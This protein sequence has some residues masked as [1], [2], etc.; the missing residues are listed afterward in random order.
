M[1]P[2]GT[3]QS[4]N[5]KWTQ[6][7]LASLGLKLAALQYKLPFDDQSAD[8]VERLFHDLMKSVDTNKKLMIE[9][10]SLKEKN[11]QMEATL[12]NLLVQRESKTSGS[13]ANGDNTGQLE[14]RV[15]RLNR[16]VE[17]L[18]FISSKL[19]GVETAESWGGASLN[20]LNL[21]M[22]YEKAL[23]EGASDKKDSIDKKSADN[24]PAFIKEFHSVW[25]AQEERDEFAMKLREKEAEISNLL[26]MPPGD[27]N[28]VK[29][30]NDHRERLFR[31]SVEADLK[32]LARVEQ[33]RDIVTRKLEGGELK[34]A[35]SILGEVSR[36]QEKVKELETL[37]QEQ[38][39]MILRLEKKLAS[40]LKKERRMSEM[41]G[42]AETT[43]S[44]RG[45]QNRML[46][47]EALEIAKDAWRTERQ[48]LEA[49]RDQLEQELISTRKELKDTREELEAVIRRST[50]IAGDFDRAKDELAFSKNRIAFF[51]KAEIE[52]Q[53]TQSTLDKQLREQDKLLMELKN[54][55]QSKSRALDEMTNRFNDAGRTIVAQDAEMENLQREMRQLM[56]SLN[57]AQDNL[58]NANG[59]MKR[60][61][62]EL[63]NTLERA[64]AY[65]DRFISQERQK[66]ALMMEIQK[67]KEI[68]RA[69]ETSQE[70]IREMSNAYK[71]LS[72]RSR[73]LEQQLMKLSSER[74][75]YKQALL[76]AREQWKFSREEFASLQSRYRTLLNEYES[77]VVEKE[78]IIN[79]PF[80]SMPPSL[81]SGTRQDAEDELH[82]LREYVETLQKELS[83]FRK[84]RDAAI[85]QRHIAMDKLKKSEGQR[86]ELEAKVR[87][88]RSATELLQKR[89]KNY[90]NRCELL[91]TIVGKQRNHILS[92]DIPL[93]DIPGYEMPSSVA[94]PSTGSS[95]PMGD[96]L[97]TP[98]TEFS[99]TPPSALSSAT[100]NMASAYA[101][102]V[103]S[104]HQPESVPVSAV[105][106][107]SSPRTVRS[108]ADLRRSPALF[109]RRVPNLLNGPTPYPVLRAGTYPTIGKHVIDLDTSGEPS[110]S[111]AC[112][113]NTE[114]TPDWISVGSE[115]RRSSSRKT[116]TSSDAAMPSS[117][118]SNE[119]TGQSRASTKWF[120]AFT[121][122][123]EQQSSGSR[124]SLFQRRLQDS[125]PRSQENSISMSQ[126]QNSRMSDIEV[127][128]IP[129]TQRPGDQSL[130]WMSTDQPRQESTT[131]AE[132]AWSAGPSSQNVTDRNWE[133]H[134]RDHI[135][136]TSSSS[137][138]SCSPL[139][140][141]SRHTGQQGEGQ[142]GD[143]DDDD[144]QDSQS[145]TLSISQQDVE[146]STGKGCPINYN[147]EEGDSISLSI[148]S[149]AQAMSTTRYYT[150]SV[151]NG[152][153][154]SLFK[155]SSESD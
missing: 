101:G 65:E 78:G 130:L 95:R 103:S 117:V 32:L 138:S 116:F 37:K 63:N 105:S 151:L 6:S 137:D 140:A 42:T 135:D 153:K 128:S 31:S 43:D 28:T 2:T 123:G 3:A 13:N 122:R 110:V 121:S 113:R 146:R 71:E 79:E 131:P 106:L 149:D 147:L 120:R 125:R 68:I 115:D 57:G 29:L 56:D 20:L 124:H 119:P 19:A 15:F 108:S 39:D 67:Q 107:P 80:S 85:E 104:N 86:M 23:A 62:E 40:F 27:E 8:L 89:L 96:R 94:Y 84:S 111:P 46:E 154:S 97:T 74:Q 18:L 118:T 102:D 60:L 148:L 61:E 64:K 48:V 11:V 83:V 69:A 98:H 134:D 51:E 22:S 141:A 1:R 38:S 81:K 4:P 16:L 54:E 77:R 24:F 82:H 155:L 142:G 90:I 75:A 47:L 36:L 53:V 59:E 58:M 72:E 126:L 44:G 66:E 21:L 152:D 93:L 109:S 87:S 91:E 136:E 12:R 52:R 100:P 7:K 14:S 30:L 133:E 49:A 55:L 45:V 139:P 17:S 112:P 10:R 92:H 143:D 129:S 99:L 76:E 150:D 50:K 145:S 88:L 34:Q 5:G 73:G 41:S 127:I 70:E 33:L 144:E 35:G 25:K 132:Q 114:T 9:V 26:L